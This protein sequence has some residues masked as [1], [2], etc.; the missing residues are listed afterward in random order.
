M[1]GHNL[2]DHESQKSEHVDGAAA[3]RRMVGKEVGAFEHPTLMLKPQ[4][5]QLL[6]LLEEHLKEMDSSW[7]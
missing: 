3:G 1:T 7:D 2:V 4:H 5:L 6:Y